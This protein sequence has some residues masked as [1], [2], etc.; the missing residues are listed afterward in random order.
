MVRSPPLVAPGW[1]SLTKKATAAREE[2][3]QNS[4]DRWSKRERNEEKKKRR[5]YWSR[6]TISGIST[7]VRVITRATVRL[8]LERGGHSPRQ[9]HEARAHPGRRSV[10]SAMSAE[11][12]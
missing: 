12:M 8:D 10:I 1:I 4:G 7:T 9:T 11:H 3:K 5:R 2:N 6:T